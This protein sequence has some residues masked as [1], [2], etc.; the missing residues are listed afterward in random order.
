[1]L[2]IPDVLRII[3]LSVEL[4]R[5]ATADKITEE[6]AVAWA[7]VIQTQAP[8][9]TYEGAQ[10]AVIRYYGQTGESLTPLGLIEEWRSMNRLLPS[11]IAADVRSARARRLIAADWYERDPL[12]PDVAAQ[13]EAA[14]AESA[15]AVELEH[16]QHTEIEK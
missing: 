15:R 7:A 10:A 11:Q 12:P 6:R 4:D 1:M 9:M 3:G 16:A 14:R 5:Y 8:A 2:T 13:L